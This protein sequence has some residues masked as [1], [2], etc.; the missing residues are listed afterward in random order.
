MGDNSVG[1]QGAAEWTPVEPD[2]Q[3]HLFS[4]LCYFTVISFSTSFSLRF[5]TLKEYTGN[6]AQVE[7]HEWRT[8]SFVPDAGH[9]EWIAAFLCHGC[10]EQEKQMLCMWLFSV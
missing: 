2:R 8:P 9:Q 7:H 5:S 3:P 10:S 1:E 4:G 6:D